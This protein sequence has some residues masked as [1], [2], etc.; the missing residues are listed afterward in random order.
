MARKKNFDWVDTIYKEGFKSKPH[1]L[2]GK[3]LFVFNY[4]FYQHDQTPMVLPYHY[5]QKYKTWMAINWHYLD[6]KVRVK[7]FQKLMAGGHVNEKGQI[8][9][10][11]NMLKGLFKD[12]SI[13]LR[14]YKSTGIRHVIALDTNDF[15]DR[16]W[17]SQGRMNEEFR[18]EMHKRSI[19]ALR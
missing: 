19:E 3:Q 8:Q 7:I 17:Q 18:R 2:R 11:T 5:E 1:S 15:I 13:C 16:Y 14:R 4:E 12:I 10:D 9:L 6:P